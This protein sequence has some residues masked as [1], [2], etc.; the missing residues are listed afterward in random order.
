MAAER[1]QKILAQ[2]GIAS[3]RKAEE[4]IVRGEV[5]INGKTAQLGDKA[6]FSK[7]AIKVQGKL[8]RSTEPLVY[9]AFYK[10]PKVISMPTDPQGRPAL[11][12]YFKKIK[13]RLFPIGRLD[14]MSEGLLLLTNDGEMTEKLT[15]SADLARVYHVKVRGMPEPEVIERVARGAKIEGK[16]IKPH[17]VQLS[18]KLSSK[19]K[20]EVVFIGAGAVDLQTFLEM[21]G[22]HVDRIVRTAIGHITLRGLQPGTYRFLKKSQ[23][24]ALVQQPELAMRALE[25]SIVPVRRETPRAPAERPGIV[26]RRDSSRAKTPSKIQ[27]KIAPKAKRPSAS[28]GYQSKSKGKVIVQAGTGSGRARHSRAAAAPDRGADRRNSKPRNR[29]LTKRGRFS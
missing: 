21:K 16:L 6:D 27:P 22:L 23:M 19:S 26:P 20:L 24:E 10:P 3:R 8:L 14:F 28:T 2:A 25:Q 17:R 4:L 5:T 15:K 7:D 29:L 1:V 9:V 12:D 13:T 18:E 11:G